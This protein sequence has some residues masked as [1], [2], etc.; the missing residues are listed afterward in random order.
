[1]ALALAP[2]NVQAGTSYSAWQ[3]PADRIGAGGTA[4]R[5]HDIDLWTNGDPARGYRILGVITRQ[6]GGG[7]IGKKSRLAQLIR[8]HGGDAGIIMGTD[9]RAIGGMALSPTMFAMAQ[10]TVVRV[11]VIKYAPPQ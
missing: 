11:L 1:M 4:E 2:S 9:S 6:H 5:V 10:R 8:Q 3:G 7:G